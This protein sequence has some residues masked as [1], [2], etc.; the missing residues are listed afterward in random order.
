MSVLSR[1]ITGSSTILPNPDEES[2]EAVLET[3]GL[4]SV[5]TKTYDTLAGKQRRPCGQYTRYDTSVRAKI[6]KFAVS[7]GNR[8]AVVNFSREM[9]H[10]ISESTIRGFKKEFVSAVNKGMEPDDIVELCH[11]KR[12]RPLLL[13]DELDLKVQGYLKKLRIAG[14]IVNHTIAIAVGKGIVNYHSPSLLI[15]NGGTLDLTYKW[16]ES[17]MKRM[18]LV[19]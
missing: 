4:N 11:R 17:L 6:A 16:A 18:D 10:P 13:S 14:G 19:R 1:V 2:H 15:E 9:G 7:H 5:V 12:G 8:A 3:R